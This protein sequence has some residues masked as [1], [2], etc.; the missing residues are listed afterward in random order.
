M[1]ATFSMSIIYIGSEKSLYELISQF[2]KVHVHGQDAEEAVIETLTKEDAM[3][4]PIQAGVTLC[5]LYGLIKVFGKEVV[6][7]LLLA[8]IGLAG[9]MLIKGF[10]EQM[11]NQT[12]KNLDEKKIINLKV[13][14][15]GLDFELTLLDVPCILLSAIAVLIYVYS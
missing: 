3:K 6:S 10:V 1:M 8:Y 5:G 15:I 4:F 2:E 7:P 9:A 13:Q 12:L 14:S 11:S